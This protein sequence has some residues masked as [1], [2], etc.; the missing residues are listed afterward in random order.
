MPAMAVDTSGAEAALPG[1]A[2][3]YL[4]GLSPSEGDAESGLKSLFDSALELLRSALGKNAATAFGILGICAIS[5][6]ASAFTSGIQ[7]V[8]QKAV[9]MA[10][11]LGILALCFSGT[12]DLM[13]GCAES[14]A[15]LGVFSKALIP[16]FAAAAAVSGKPVSAV[17]A[18]GASMLF[19]GIIVELADKVFIPGIYLFLTASAAGIIGEN[20][21]L[22]RLSDLIKW[23]CHTF[24]RLFLTAFMFYISVTGV[25]SGGADAAAVKTAQVTISSVLPV[26]GGI[27][28]DA[29]DAILT[30]A[31]VLRSS[32]GVFGSLGAC[33][34]CLVPMVSA[35]SGYLVF[36][37]LSAAASSFASPG[38]SRMLDSLGAAYG[39]VMGILG[40]C[41]ALQFIS[42]IVSTV[43]TK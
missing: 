2:R 32:L 37:I 11:V 31:S 15:S 12:N 19:S 24:F 39:L 29:S 14:V 34:V 8:S 25:V 17:A 40:S 23:A 28:S 13:A 7:G 26:L 42:L 27:V 21:L 4:G 36:K 35:F 18:S 6:V 5:S 16:V 1:Q 43:V 30:G 38:A 33:A 20:R 41:C 10:A 22:Q 3:E 9:D